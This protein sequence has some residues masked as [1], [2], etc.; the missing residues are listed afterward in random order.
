M[1]YFALEA[2]AKLATEGIEC[3]IV[4]P[5]TLVPLDKEAI[6]ESVAKTGR[7]VVVHEAPEREAL[8]RKWRR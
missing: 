2:A 1:V 6:L 8:G 3:E 5:R 7:L 4:D